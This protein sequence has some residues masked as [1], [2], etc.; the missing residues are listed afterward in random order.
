MKE[1]IK[2]TLNK[3]LENGRGV[4]I[5][6]FILELFLTIFITPN[7]YDDEWFIKQI[8]DELNVETNEIIEH[9]I[10]DFVENRYHNWSSRV[11][12]EFVLC[13]VLKTSKYLW[14]L[15][16]SLMAVLVCYSLSKIFIKENKKQNAFMLMLMILIYPYYT[17]NQT[18]WAS[19]SINY[20]WPLAA[21]L[22]ALIPIKKAWDG[23]KIKW[24]QYPLYIISLIFAANQEQAGA[25]LLGFYLVFSSLMIFRKDKKI[26]LFIIIQTIISI[27]SIV[28]ILTCPGNSIRQAEE[29]YRF[30]GYEML[31]FIE[32]FVLGFTAT[33]GD[34]IS[35]QN[36]VYILLTS[37]MTLYVHLNYKEKLYRIISSIPLLS[38]LILG[39]FLPLLNGMFP[40]LSVF[41]ELITE[42]N[43]LLTV[44]N[45]N[46][47][48]Y[49]FPIIFAFG[50]FIC[51]G[52]TLL[53][54][55]KN[56]KNNVAI[57]IFLAGLASRVIVAF[58]P[59]I[60]VSKTRTMIFFD[61]S[62]IAI[63]YLIWEELSKN[64]K[65]DKALNIVN[66]LIKFSAVVQVLNTIIYIY[67]KQKLY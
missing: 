38:V 21:G 52:M 51:I 55:F 62:M 54:I 56:L 49:A 46:N 58:S 2:K 6:L 32:K 50:N 24:W 53:L 28:F 29:L 8:T 13:S 17:M 60:F 15:I 37:I 34:I 30:K 41:K 14:I 64:K 39:T 65:H 22:F 27:L 9:S 1:K 63:T 23:E 35:K 11:V 3:I 26:K 47:I 5:F 61:F 19:T 25:V 18:G 20:L 66:S 59:T 4:L 10:P 67:S 43:V 7:T 40:Y 16:Q 44:A 33:F 48:Y 31:S 57:L 42:N 45:C 36:T 12:I